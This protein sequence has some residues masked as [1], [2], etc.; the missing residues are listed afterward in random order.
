[1]DLKLARLRDLR[2]QMESNTDIGLDLSQAEDLNLDNFTYAGNDETED[3]GFF[4]EERVGNYDYLDLDE[5]DVQTIP[6]PDID[7]SADSELEDVFLDS[8]QT[9]ARG[10]G[11]GNRV[12]MEHHEYLREAREE[13]GPDA[14]VVLVEARKAMHAGI[15]GDRL[16]EYLASK[17]DR[18]HLQAAGPELNSY[19][20][21]QHLLGNVILEPELFASC[22]KLEAFLK[23]NKVAGTAKFAK[24]CS[25]CQDCPLRKKSHCQ[26]FAATLVKELPNDER[27]FTHYAGLLGEQGKVSRKTAAATQLQARDYR[28][29]TAALFAI[30]ETAP[31]LRREVEAA[32]P[33]TAVPERRGVAQTPR[34][35]LLKTVSNLINEGAHMDKIKEA[36]RTYLGTTPFE[37][38]AQTAMSRRG[39]MPW[40]SFGYC[41]HPLLVDKKARFTLEAGAN[42]G[43]CVQN[44][45]DHCHLNK[46]SFTESFV[47]SS[48]Y[49]EVPA[50]ISADEQMFI[51]ATP[52]MDVSPSEPS[53]PELDVHDI[54]GLDEG[55][56][57]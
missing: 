2:I 45:G 38:V 46:R 28:E 13:R 50:L 8:Y 56:E 40:S 30:A 7:A 10:D 11:A 54:G 16:L 36:T 57:V 21:D 53:S 51:D 15:R 49:A 34:L 43:D 3:L 52:R 24:T 37:A 41:D 17:F 39:S 29:A 5:E 44:Y 47:D 1:M 31:V 55:F 18:A 48:R 23:D 14:E 26:K 4:F 32:Q 12:S 9:H 6:S 22:E 33:N 27:V 42:C 20:I 35:A 19:V 25:D